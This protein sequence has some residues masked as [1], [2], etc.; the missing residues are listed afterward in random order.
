MSAGPN[1]PLGPISGKAATSLGPRSRP[2]SRESIDTFSSGKAASVPA[3]ASVVRRR[4]SDQ[5]DASP[6]SDFGTTRSSPASVSPRMDAATG[7]T[8]AETTTSAASQ[9]D[10]PAISDHRPSATK[11]KAKPRG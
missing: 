11:G 2:H 9:I 3:A 4:D 10:R 1:L 5:D 6:R 7:Y 8:V